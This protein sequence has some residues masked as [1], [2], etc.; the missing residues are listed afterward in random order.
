[1]KGHISLLHTGKIVTH[2]CPGSN[3]LA[4]LL[5]IANNHTNDGCARNQLKIRRI[6]QTQVTED[7][8]VVM[9]INNR[10]KMTALNYLDGTKEMTLMTLLTFSQ[11]I[12]LQDITILGSNTWVSVYHL[13]CKIQKNNTH[14]NLLCLQFTICLYFK[15]MYVQFLFYFLHL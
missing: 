4:E 3:Y 11:D 14:N 5:P 15:S 9:P 1:M 12:G 6:N 10:Y 7:K 13:S 2:R 8:D